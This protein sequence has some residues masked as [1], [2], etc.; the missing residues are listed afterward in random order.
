MPSE[1]SV[2]MFSKE[3]VKKNFIFIVLLLVTIVC[4]I[5]KDNYLPMSIVTHPDSYIE[6]TS[7]DGIM[8]Q[9]WLSQ[10]K[11]ISS[12]NISCIAEN[13]FQDTMTMTIIDNQSEEVI[14]KVSQSVQFNADE[15]KK[16]CF[17]FE[18][19]GIEIGNQYIFRLEYGNTK[20]DNILMIKSGSDY[21]GCSIGGEEVN[22]GAAIE[23]IYKKNSTIFWLFSS[24][25]PFIGMGFLFMM[26][27]DRK[28]EEIVGVSMAAIIFA[29][30][31]MGL[32]GKL[33]IGV[34]LV[35]ALSIIAFIAGIVLYNK[36]EKTV[37][38][39]VSPGLMVYGVFV[40]LILVN[41]AD[42]RL[43][44]WDEF[45][46]WGLAAKDM[47]YSNSFA[48]HFDST[49]MLK[50]YPPVATLIEYFFCYTNKFFSYNMIY[51]GFQVFMLNLLSVGMGI[52]K[53]EKKKYAIPIAMLIL[54]A[55]VI[56]FN[57]VYNCIYVDP[58]LAFGVAYILIC[59]YTEKMSVYNFIRIIG[60]LFLLT[61]TKDTGVVLSGLLTLVMLGD[62]LYQQFKEHK[63]QIKK[64]QFK[65]IAWT[66]SSTVFVCA[67]FFLWQFF[68]S[69][70][71]ERNVSDTMAVTQEI[72]EAEKMSVSGAISNSGINIS[73]LM[74]LLK[75]D[76]GGYRYT[77]I[78]NYIAAITG[79]NVYSF[80]I[81][82][83]SYVDLL[84]VIC[85][86]LFILYFKGW[87]YQNDDRSLSFGV[88]SAIAAL[89]Y[90]GF[91]LI[92]Y[93]FS[94]GMGEAIILT[95]Y[96]RYLAS[97]IAGISIAMVAVLLAG[98]DESK[99]TNI[100][101]SIVVI[102]AVLMMATPFKEF[103]IKNMDIE[104]T[105]AQSYG[106]HEIANILYSEAEKTDS[107]F[108]VC[109]GSDGYANFQFKNAVVPMQSSLWQYDLYSSKES[110]LEQIEIDK[111]S[112]RE[113][114]GSPCYLEKEEWAKQLVNYE[115]V[116]L[117]YPNEMFKRDYAGL[118]SEPE[119]I[120]QGTVYR[121]NKEG[122]ELVLDYIGK[123]G[124]K[125]FR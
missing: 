80:G 58:L 78:K 4:F 120:E 49:V 125:E 101:I 92:T 100:N 111:E 105:E 41:C 67:L 81:I 13:D 75:G 112:M 25:L 6:F 17:E 79:E 33:E 23:I 46:H 37:V 102:C 29:M 66:A 9:T 119:T 39:L 64:F 61:L 98:L 82:S 51:V 56:F 36:K 90:A 83:F 10:V 26:L 45:S 96:V 60:G 124:I 88:L 57:D 1:E 114:G 15:E 94:F 43:A 42:M 8:E 47:F 63:F 74:N 21:M 121:V 5:K 113:I 95:S 117:F 118:F 73:G 38:D 99:S 59:Y 68:L 28:W 71:M 24:F 86:I 97:C 62:T 76:D 30:F 34:G 107:I 31:I 12:V 32:F 89:G 52:C 18:P 93:L 2:L 11:E 19:I 72:A 116:V 20:A 65:R 104:V 106:Y 109:N 53:N 7:A 108:F 77:V 22:Q 103:V 35:Y 87:F 70:P 14:T 48:K 85:L 110:Y 50:S 122:T 84:I 16:L 115:Y 3:F 40:V 91:L 27:W 54:F 44:R 123:T 69:V 55:P